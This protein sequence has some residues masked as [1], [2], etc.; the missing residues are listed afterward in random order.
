MAVLDSKLRVYGI[1]H[2]RVAD[3]SVFPRSPSANLQGPTMM[4]AERAA[5]FIKETWK[6]PYLKYW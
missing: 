3:A 5:D 1:K 2:L 6:S 4:V